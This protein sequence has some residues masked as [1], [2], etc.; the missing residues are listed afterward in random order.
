MILA[1]EIGVVIHSKLQQAL[2]SASELGDEPGVHMQGV[3]EL[4]VWLQLLL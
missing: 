3:Q 1:A 4:K 2:P